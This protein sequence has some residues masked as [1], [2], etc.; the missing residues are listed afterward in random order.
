[1]IRLT[2]LFLFLFCLTGS[3]FAQN[4]GDNL[5]D[6]ATLH[7]V[8]LTFLEADYWR[9]LTDNFN[10]HA[11]PNDP[12]PYLMA[13]MTIDGETVDSIGVR[14]KGFTSH[15]ASQTKKP[16]KLDLN[17]FVSGKR[18]DGLRKIN[19]N[20]ATADPGM[21]RDLICYDLMNAMGVNAPR[22]AYARVYLN[23]NYYGVY[24]LVEQVDKEF[25]QNN[26]E[27]SKGNLFKNKG[28]F[29]FEFSGDDTD[30]YRIME[31]KTNREGDDYSG[32]INFIDILNNSSEETFPAA[33]EEVFDV[34][35]YLK[36]LAIDV[37]TDNWDSNLEHGRNWYMYEDTT[38][39]V[40]QWIPWDYN[41][42]LG[43]DLFGGGGGGGDEC[44]VFADPAMLLNGTTT[45]QFY[46]AGFVVG[47]PGY[48]WDF[49]DRS[50]G[51][52]EQ[53]P[54]HTY[55]TPGEY[56]VCVTMT[57]TADCFSERCKTINTATN[58]EE[59]PSIVDGSYGGPADSIFALLL[60]YNPTCCDMWG[61]DCEDIKTMLNDR[62]NGGGG[63]G[64]GGF[65]SGFSIDQRAND[66]RILIRRLLAVPDFYDR[67][68]Q[69]FCNLMN[70]HFTSEKYDVVMAA[71]KSLIENSVAEDPHFLFSYEVF[72]QDFGEEGLKQV[73]AERTAALLD[74]LDMMDGCA[75]GLPN[76]P[77]GD[78][79]IN[80]FVADNDSISGI[81]DPDGGY[82]DWI[83]LY[84][85]TDAPLDLSETYLSDKNDNFQKWQ[86]PEGTSIPADGYLIIWADED[87]EQQGLHAN[88]K[89]SRN[90]EAIYLSNADGTSIDS[91]SFGEQTTNVSF[92]RVPN[93]T[94]DFAT[95]HT[96]HG[97]SN[98][99]PVATQNIVNAL[100][101]NVYP[102]PAGDRLQVGLPANGTREYTAEI[103]S[104]TGQ[105]VM[106]DQKISGPLAILK[107]NNLVPGFYFLRVRDEAGKRGVV[108][109]SKR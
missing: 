22:V 57:L 52:T 17:E 56:E 96:T 37:A 35:R 26:F 63:S 8:R 77:V 64:G 46:D 78:L 28:W 45:V 108:K 105:Q 10:E 50:S 74:D 41:L 7:E 69:H 15:G 30:A 72:E 49:G 55:A 71:N 90:G 102:N 66:E 14:Q 29:N 68:V 109:F 38:T 82:P 100:K 80:E 65:G 54:E 53:N 32:L 20:N 23:D 12:V 103:Y 51:S 48:A 3:L 9:I 24:Q 13:S 21:Q 61:E 19:L 67:Y 31:L 81:N 104:V 88:F 86:F 93:G 59:C 1:M 98:D 16:L 106:V 47:D 84:N 76:I 70:N 33:I 2:G 99:T 60:T 87:Q 75:P 58:L 83:E 73:I 34:D 27:N 5:Y 4:S 11:D 95:Q 89:L 44:L 18:Y 43:A 101:V 85:N 36:T 92:S 39:G 79:A 25:L 42:A 97:Y 91:I 107:V 6:L 94:G 62:G 40:F